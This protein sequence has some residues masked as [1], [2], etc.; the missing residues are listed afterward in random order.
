M[1][2]PLTFN[3]VQLKF[4]GKCFSKDYGEIETKRAFRK[5][6]GDSHWLRKLKPY[7]FRRAYDQ[8]LKKGAKNSD[9][10]VPK[11]KNKKPNEAAIQVVKNYFEENPSHSLRK[12]EAKI[13]PRI[14]RSTVFDD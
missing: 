8:F 14:P 11:N 3:P 12:A 5:E 13:E 1:A 7:S 9:K 10:V 2:P 6:F 4:I